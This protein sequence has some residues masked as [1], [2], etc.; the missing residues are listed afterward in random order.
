MDENWQ[1]LTEAATRLNRDAR[2]VRRLCQKWAAEGKARKMTPPSG[3]QSQWFVRSDVTLPGKPAE[4]AKAIATSFDTSRLTK[5]QQNDLFRRENIVRGWMGE[6]DKSPAKG[7]KRTKR[8]DAYL[9]SIAAKFGAMSRAN[10]YRLTTAYEQSSLAGL[11]D[12]RVRAA[13]RKASVATPGGDT[14]D[15]PTVRPATQ[16]HATVAAAA[17]G[18]KT[19]ELAG[20]AS[21]AIQTS[22]GAI[23]II[24]PAGVSGHEASKIIQR[25]F[26]APTTGV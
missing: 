7:K 13:L 11:L 26:D 15:A 25:F 19:G 6:R 24:L 12:G 10:L 20:F 17:T 2:H 23:R 4:P 18:T 9:L 21:L 16:A 22:K 8:A 5:L 14:A 3:G 1:N